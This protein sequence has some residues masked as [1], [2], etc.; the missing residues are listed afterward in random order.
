MNVKRRRVST[1]FMKYYLLT[2]HPSQVITPIQIRSFAL[3]MSIFLN[4]STALAVTHYVDPNSP[5]PASPYTS[6]NTASHDIQIAVDASANGDVVLVTNGFYRSGQRAGGLMGNRVVVNNAVTVQS[7]NG[8]AVTTIMGFQ[9]PGTVTSNLSIRCVYLADGA[10]L[11]GF[12]LTGGSTLHDLSAD[13]GFGGAVF[14][15][16]TNAV[17]SNCVLTG[18]AAFSLGGGAYRVTLNNCTISENR[19]M[20]RFS[21][22]A[23]AYPY[24]GGA[25]GCVANNCIF[26]GNRSRK[27]GGAATD[28]I[29]NNC[30]IINNVV[31]NDPFYENF[32]EPGDGGGLAGA[33]PGLA[34]GL[35]AQANDCLFVGNT[36]G[37]AGGGAA[38]AVLNN[39]TLINNTAGAA[40]GGAYNCTLNNC[41]DYYNAAPSGSNWFIA[42]WATSSI[43]FS[44]TTPTPTN[45]TDN[46]TNEPLLAAPLQLSTGSPCIG[47]GSSNYTSGVDLN[48]NAWSN[49]PSMGCAEYNPITGMTSISLNL[50]AVAV[51][52]N[53]SQN[54]YA[55]ASG[56]ITNGSWTV[57]GSGVATN[58][59]VI[60]LIWPDPGAHSIEFHALDAGG[61]D[62]SSTV[63]VQVVESLI[64]YVSADGTNPVPP[65]VSWETAATNIQDAV[66]AAKFFPAT[67]LVSDGVYRFGGGVA[68]DE[69]CSNRVT[70]VKPIAVQS[71][72][73]QGATLIQG[74]RLPGGG[75]GIADNA[76]RCIYLANGATLTGFTLTNGATGRTVLEGNVVGGGAYCEST[77]ESLSYCVIVG[78][79]AFKGAGGV[80]GGT[81]KYCNIVS[82]VVVSFG[83]GGGVLS[84]MLSECVVQG[85]R[86][87]TAGGGAAFAHLN[88]CTV[89]NNNSGGAFVCTLNNC[90]VYYN[91][92][93]NIVLSNAAANYCCTFPL[94]TNGIGNIT[95]EPLFIDAAADFHLQFTS[96]CINSGN[97][98]YVTG[99][100]DLDG[101][102]RIAGGTVDIGA[103][104]LPSPASVISYAWLKQFGLA[105]DGSADFT[106]ADADGL[107]NWQEWRAGT[108]PTSS[109][110]VLQLLAPS[111]TGPGVNVTWQS[112]SG[113]NY[114]LQRSAA[115]GTGSFSTIRS[116]IAGQN[117]TTT[118]TDT[119]ATIPGPFFYRVGVQ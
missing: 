31:E 16:S 74:F 83:P 43:H 103:Y 1:C 59:P 40:G 87:G 94:P 14:G 21:P 118:C 28:C 46:I 7:V 15:A 98:A 35:L 110:S 27:A 3:V 71:V 37:D 36:A 6:W 77:N 63:S 114:F 116:N 19:T 105:T 72:N 73:G 41:I 75:S 17:V 48:G 86:A 50:F 62:I 119:N 106:D 56:S 108:V 89:A 33:G 20:A 39:C 115:L 60:S 53:F 32:T 107:S 68:A 91:S 18:N 90:I 30:H 34:T 69:Y 5:A 22:T 101:N 4:A 111:V 99:N 113:I 76:I 44:C 97:N 88:N 102:A 109:L 93:Q 51:P 26:Q 66:D 95:N 13:D 49:P 64:H 92:D 81:L 8:P 9:T 38:G 61:N 67:V 58:V 11:V 10:S 42:Y 2:Q 57:D 78:N 117:G 23:H 80:F 79:V 55:T 47:T 65:F 84:N 100:S 45:G 104:E 96:P 112:V 85:N 25:Y 29:L 52:T 12:T 70:V 54:I 82:N 24:G